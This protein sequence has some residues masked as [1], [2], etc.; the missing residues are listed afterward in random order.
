[1]HDGWTEISPS[2]DAAEPNVRRADPHHPLNFWRG[3]DAQGRYV[4]QLDAEGA[5]G[6][7]SNWPEPAG[8][9][10]EPTDLGSGRYQLR[11]GLLDSTNR[12]LFRAL[13]ATLME[14]TAHLTPGTAH[15]ALSIVVAQLFKWQSMLARRKADLLSEERVIG[16]FGELLFLRDLLLA[17][18]PAHHAIIAWRGPYGDEQDFIVQGAIFEIKTS[19]ATADARISISSEN[20][21]DTSSCP[22]VLCRQ[23][24]SPGMGESARSLNGLVEEVVTVFPD[25]D[26]AAGDLF[27]RGLLEA[28]YEPRPEYDGPQWILTGRRGFEVGEDFP[29]ITKS[30][31]RAGVE[32][33]QYCVAIDAC[34]PFAI[35]VEHRMGGLVDG[36][37]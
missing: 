35:D 27:Q 19:L 14:A 7:V 29:R 10:V 30:D 36:A 24:L 31:L 22:I 16:L 17:R 11:L 21:L 3:R 12:Q 23:N 18:M 8:I 33:V 37:V 20:Q 4:F 13:C 2:P 25:D 34:L 9:T 1:M 26:P 28:G 15:S 32:R 5:L 6:S